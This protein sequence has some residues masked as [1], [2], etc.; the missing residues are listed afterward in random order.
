MTSETNRIN[1][2]GLMCVTFAMMLMV[3]L[4]AAAV[5]IIVGPY[6]NMPSP[7]GMVIRFETDV[8]ASA[9]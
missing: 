8:P 6:M 9:E 7:T 1:G 4:N 3:S 2:L 5:E